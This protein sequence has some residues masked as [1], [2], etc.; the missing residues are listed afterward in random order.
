MAVGRYTVSIRDEIS[1]AASVTHTR[2]KSSGR[3]SPVGTGT[4]LYQS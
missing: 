2:Y 3:A 4:Y 1:Y